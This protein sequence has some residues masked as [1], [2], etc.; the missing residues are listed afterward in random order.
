MLKFLCFQP[1]LRML[2]AW[3]LVVLAAEALLPAILSA[4]E[5]ALGEVVRP[6]LAKY[7]FDCHGDGAESERL[8]LDQLG[9]S[10]GDPIQAQHWAKVLEQL[11]TGAMPP[12]DSDQPSE[13]ERHTI[14]QWIDTRLVDAA[15]ERHRTQGRVVLRRLN[16]VEYENTLR[17]LLGVDVDVKE[18]LPDD[19][20][21]GGFDN[22]GE[23]LSTSA[24]LMDRY[25][26][27]AGVALAAAMSPVSTVEP[28]HAR[29]SY[30]DESQVA[31]NTRWFRETDD[32]VVF[33]NPKYSPT[34]LRQFKSPAPG[35]YRFRVSVRTFQS[36]GPLA[37]AVYTGGLLAAKDQKSHLVGYFDVPPGEPRVIEF[38]DRLVA[39]RHSIKL[40]PYGTEPSDAKLGKDGAALVYDGPGLEVQWVEVDGPLAHKRPMT[41]AARLIAGLGDLSPTPAEAQRVVSQF[42]TCA[43]RR[44]ITDEELTP[45]HDLVASRLE[46]GY[47]FR[48]AVR[49]GLQAVLCSPQFLLLEEQPGPLDAYALASRLS[50]FLWSSMP[51]E[52]L[53][54]LA[55]TS[56]LHE[57][58]VLRREVERM[59][60]DAKA[61]RFTEDF[62]GQ[63][64]DLRLIDFTTP[65][66]RRYRKFDE[67]LKTSMVKETLLFFKEM[68]DH[69]LSVVNFVD[70]D[71]TFLNE[72][73]A[74]HYGI[75][76][77][78]GYEQMRKVSLPEGSHRGGVLTHA[79][80]L[81]V[82]AN[83][84]DTSPVVRGAWVLRKILGQ[85]PPPPPQN[86]P[87]LEP[88]IRGATTIR[89][90]LGQH[91]QM[92]TCAGCHA[93]ID[94]VGFALENFDVI[95]GWREFYQVVE[96]VIV[97]GQARGIK[98]QK[99]PPIEP[100]DTL[101]N[102]K[103][104]TSVDD[105]KRLLCEDGSQ[106]AR[107]VTEQLVAYATGG[108]VDL[109]DRADI[110]QIVT[111]TRDGNYGLRSLIHAIVQSPTF[112]NK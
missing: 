64:L 76:G 56:K 108:S 26:E 97:D 105:F 51:D 62:V 99:G 81:K 2:C 67:L 54:E 110:D 14:E 95:G 70:S 88:D 8:R 48:D 24:V 19:P 69:D 68:L 1:T 13:A 50:Y 61:E 60:G 103:T 4:A 34:T 101:S 43:F 20:L 16:R 72:S 80:V 44:P 100:A 82:T 5:P 78:Q 38:T 45:I 49:L 6:L 89:Q 27:A 74:R 109:G 66:M 73:L 92:A 11:R 35:H 59:L 53:L 32:G 87:A 111:S 102:G 65:D 9:E 12:K 90:R 37:L 75:S 15:R 33:F 96:P 46:A 40:V 94:P 17:D 36:A 41:P 63:W 107:A 42:A 23:A 91:R 79:S 47:A 25:L 98:V 52:R 21:S 18:L 28:L 85:P 3:S 30:K 7:C 31:R 106:I 77:V 57:P 58:D 112:Q 29:Y 55:A 104:F 71:F 84:T 86:V 93:K 10:F 22:N 83:G 39:A